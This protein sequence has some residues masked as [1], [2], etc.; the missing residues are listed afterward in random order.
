M[1]LSNG[2][3][4]FFVD[5]TLIFSNARKGA[6]RVIAQVRTIYAQASSQEVNFSN[7]TVVFSKNVE[8]LQQEVLA[9]GGSHRDTRHSK[10]G[11]IRPIL[12]T[13]NDH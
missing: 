4:S 3:T 9:A 12:G 7:S 6:M 8:V 1:A 5:E 11:P 10:G 13:F 2:H